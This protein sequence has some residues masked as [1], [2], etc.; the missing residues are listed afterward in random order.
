MNDSTMKA[1]CEAPTER[2]NP[3]GIATAAAAARSEKS[4]LTWTRESLPRRPLRRVLGRRLNAGARRAGRRVLLTGRIRLTDQVEWSESSRVRSSLSLDRARW[5][6][7]MQPLYNGDRFWP[8]ADSRV[9]SNDEPTGFDLREQSVEQLPEGSFG[10][11]RERV[12]DLELVH[13]E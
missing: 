12:D 1:F 2:Q 13:R 9:R 5:C 7:L 8:G 10:T 6:P 11:F 3:T 4:R